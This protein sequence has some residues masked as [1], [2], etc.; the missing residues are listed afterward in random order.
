M[1]EKDYKK[2]VEEYEKLN[3]QRADMYPLS[4]EDTYKDRRREISMVCSKEAEFADKIKLLLRMS[5]DGN[6]LLK[7]YLAFKKRDMEYLNDILYENAQM[8][9]ITNVSSPGTDHTYFAY[10]IMPELLA[11]NMP[12]RIE[13]ILPEENGPAKGSV[14]GTPIVNTFMG[15]WY[16]NGELLETGLAQTEKKLGQKIS[17]FEKAY[18]SCIKD[19]ALKDTT[20]LETDLNELCKAHVKRRDFDMTPFTKGFCIEAHA[21]YNMLH[22]VYGGE[23][24]GKVKMPEEKNFCQELAVWQREHGYIHGKAVTV[25]PGD[26]DI[27]NKMLCCEPPKMGL[28]KEGRE[29]F[30]DVDKYAVEVAQRLQEMG[31]TLSKGKNSPIGKL[32]QKIKHK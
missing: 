4:L 20:A 11:A 15:I 17:A 16:Q 9:Q 7:L 31:A 5:D 8:A 14:S 12:D 22:W 28:V 2:I 10:N 29:R 23:L 13:L 1:Q 32:F 3:S 24:E 18:L 19:V 30:I 25:Y 27:F 21:I 26:M 6:P